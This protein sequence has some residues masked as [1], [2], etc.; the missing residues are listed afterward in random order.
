VPEIPFR[1]S[2]ERTATAVLV[3][4]WLVLLTATH[5]PREI[6]PEGSQLLAGDKLLHLSAY[7]GLGFLLMLVARLRQPLVD[8]EPRATTWQVARLGLLTSVAGLLD[9]L[10]QPLFGRDFELYDWLADSAGGL[11]GAA[12]ALLA[13]RFFSAA[14]NTT[15]R[16]TGG[17]DPSRPTPPH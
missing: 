13:L 6:F 12:L 14:R 2:A 7:A 16:D 4:Y 17:G 10:T 3:V 5:W 9:E 8:D 11:C 1:R 15:A